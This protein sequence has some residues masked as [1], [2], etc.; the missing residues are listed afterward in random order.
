MTSQAYPGPAAPTTDLDQA[1]CDLAEHGYCIV[2][3]ALSCE[4]NS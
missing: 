4:I 3:E 2:L 1:R